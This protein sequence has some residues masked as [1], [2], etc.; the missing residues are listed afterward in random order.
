MAKHDLVRPSRDGDHFHYHW[1]A[2]QCLALLPGKGDL[3]VTIEGPS[4]IE[5][6]G[7][8]E[9]GD[10]LIDVGLYYGSEA[11]EDARC[12]RYI[13]LKHST[14]H[15]LEAW[16]ASG[17]EKTIRGFAQ[18]YASLLK[19]L[20]VAELKRKVRFEFTTNRPIDSK[21]REA[22]DDLANAATPR[23]PNLSQ[24]VAAYAK[25]NEVQVT[26]F[27]QLF[28]A[29][30]GAPSLWGQRNLLFQDIST[31]LPEADYDSPVQLKELITR[32]ATT[33]FEKDPSIRRHDVLR[34]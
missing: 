16:T 32:K 17:L 4:A 24:A 13:Q 28:S 21:L 33:E 11:L 18:R 22:L 30:G 23:H 12:V 31:Y 7:S 25:I 15:A 27:F 1:A 10:E 3:A 8:L 19:R 6:D 26:D 14:R 34:G 5:A 29:D 20:P 9:A 2:R